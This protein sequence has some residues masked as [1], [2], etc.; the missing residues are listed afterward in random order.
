MKYFDRVDS[1]HKL[2]ICIAMGDIEGVKEGAE[3]SFEEYRKDAIWRI[4]MTAIS[5]SR[6]KVFKFLEEKRLVDLSS[7]SEFVPL[8]LLQKFSLTTLL[9]MG[10]THSLLIVTLPSRQCRLS[11]RL[12]SKI[13]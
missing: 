7:E 3:K 9:G 13:H 5:N 2:I 4:T 12:L 8:F 11:T 1:W 6:W 10:N